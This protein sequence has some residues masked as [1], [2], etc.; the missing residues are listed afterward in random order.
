MCIMCVGVGQSWRR[1]TAQGGHAAV[2]I[3]C[4]YEFALRVR[5]YRMHLN[6]H[7]HRERERES[8]HT[9]KDKSRAVEVKTVV[10]Q[11]QCGKVWGGADG[12]PV[13]KHLALC[14]VKACTRTY[15]VC[16]V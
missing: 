11:L 7:E 15:G 16:F 5:A 2:R 14:Y 6:A 12:F 1:E 4:P 3:V 13:A 10:L 9:A 8:K